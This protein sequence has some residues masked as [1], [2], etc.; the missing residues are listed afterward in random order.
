MGNVSLKKFRRMLRK[1]KGKFEIFQVLKKN[2]L[3]SLG[4]PENKEYRD[5]IFRGILKKYE[6][7]IKSD[8]SPGI[9]PKL[10]EDHGIVVSV[11]SRWVETS[12]EFVDSL[13]EKK[14]VRTDKSPQ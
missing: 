12:K 13:V 11:I 2:K 10:S 7:V 8:L 6:S 3:W 14:K 5:D 4:M 9:P 1:P